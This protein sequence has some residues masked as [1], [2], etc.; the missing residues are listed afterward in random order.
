[1]LHYLAVYVRVILK[2]PTVSWYFWGAG[3]QAAGGVSRVRVLS[4]KI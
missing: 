4:L 2:P 1:V 3:A